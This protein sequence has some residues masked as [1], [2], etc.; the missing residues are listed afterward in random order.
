MRL[1]LPLFNL[2]EGL[3]HC[4]VWHAV[5]EES[6]RNSVG[7]LFFVRGRRG[8]NGYRHANAGLVALNQY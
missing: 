6:Q 5:W 1:Q 3:S 2:L 8:R 7:H 4:P